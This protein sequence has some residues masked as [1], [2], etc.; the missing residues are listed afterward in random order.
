VVGCAVVIEPVSNGSKHGAVSIA[1]AYTLNGRP[2]SSTSTSSGSSNA[3]VVSLLPDEGL[4]P[5]L[6][7][8]AGEQ[9]ELNLGTMHFAHAPDGYCAVKDAFAAD[10]D[11]DND[12]DDGYAAATAAVV[13][14]EEK[15]DG[16]EPIDL[17]HEQHSSASAL[18]ELY[19]ADHLKAELARRGLKAGGTHT[20]RA[21]RLF[22]VRGLSE[23][24]IEAKLR[25]KKK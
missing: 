2:L 10:N 4:F 8:E 20:E 9:L 7:L 15:K 6:S 1:V 5:A 24:K 13:Q 21:S 12:N 19:S 23:D 22:A 11:N 3:V 18:Q 17:E 14:E 25:A 16:G